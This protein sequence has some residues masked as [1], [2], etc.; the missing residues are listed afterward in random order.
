[1]E[2]KFRIEIESLEVFAEEYI[3]YNTSIPHLYL[4]FTQNKK[5]NKKISN[6]ERNE[7]HPYYRQFSVVVLVNS[8][9][10]I[11]QIIYNEYKRLGHKAIFKSCSLFEIWTGLGGKKEFILPGID[12]DFYNFIIEEHHT[13]V[14]VQKGTIKNL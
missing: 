7:N 4:Y 6:W 2:D 13:E 11:S 5:L 14:E 3:K 1:M 9:A 10:E 8:D 12:A